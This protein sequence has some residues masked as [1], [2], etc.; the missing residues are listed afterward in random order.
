MDEPLARVWTN[1]VGRLHGPMQFRLVLQPLMAVI[2]AVRAGVRDAR[3]GRP[4]YG[5][6]LAFRAKARRAPVRSGWRDI[7]SVFIVAMLIDV[8]YQLI[9]L[10]WVYPGETVIVAFLLAAV[11]YIPLRALVNR[12]ARLWQ[13]KVRQSRGSWLPAPAA[14][15][16]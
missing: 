12:L 3:E 5:W 4:P 10:R 14:S 2:L 13:Q 6:A 7:A 8:V 15:H 16:A 11:P 1:L 9:V